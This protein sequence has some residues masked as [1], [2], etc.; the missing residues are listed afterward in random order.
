MGDTFFVE[1]F[2]WH[3]LKKY[4]LNRVFTKNFS[5]SSCALLSLALQAGTV[6]GFCWSRFWKELTLPLTG[7]KST[8]ASLSTGISSL[9]A[10]PAVKN[11]KVPQLSVKGRCSERSIWLLLGVRCFV[12]DSRGKQ[13]LKKI[14][15]NSF[16]CLFLPLLPSNFSESAFIFSFWAAFE[17]RCMFELAH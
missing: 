14:N 9:W 16:Y 12:R 2:Q 6:H 7:G 8:A 4:F 5:I 15:Q 10:D 13:E 11:E 17:I 3:R 1:D